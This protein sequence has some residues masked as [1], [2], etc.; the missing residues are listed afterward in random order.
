MGMGTYVFGNH[1]VDLAGP[2]QGRRWDEEGPCFR[3]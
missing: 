2:E 3:D 1:D